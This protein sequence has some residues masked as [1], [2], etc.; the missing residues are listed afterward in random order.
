MKYFVFVTRT[1]DLGFVTAIV[2]VY[3]TV[4]SLSLYLVTL[5][6]PESIKHFSP[7]LLIPKMLAAELLVIELLRSTIVVESSN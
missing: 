7:R 2:T 1:Y 5:P 3:V 4:R 6:P